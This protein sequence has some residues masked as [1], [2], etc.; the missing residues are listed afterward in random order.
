MP[1]N[2]TY[3]FSCKLD[4]NVNRRVYKSLRKLFKNLKRNKTETT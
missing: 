4:L 2:A 1:F 3:D